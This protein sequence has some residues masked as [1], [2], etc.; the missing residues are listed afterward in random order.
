MT[1]PCGRGGLADQARKVPAGGNT[2]PSPSGPP[3][4]KAVPPRSERGARPHAAVRLWQRGVQLRLA[5]A[6][7][8]HT[9]PCVCKALESRQ[10]ECS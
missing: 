4:S 1:A 3:Q 2:V 6:L 10:G 7:G 5:E 9:V 8:A